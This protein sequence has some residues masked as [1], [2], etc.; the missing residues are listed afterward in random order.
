MKHWEERLGEEVETLEYCKYGFCQ[1]CS[2]K[3]WKPVNIKGICVCYQ[4]FKER[5]EDIMQ[6]AKELLDSSRR[7]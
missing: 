6:L 5:T 2:A 1:C 7:K 4:C 3:N